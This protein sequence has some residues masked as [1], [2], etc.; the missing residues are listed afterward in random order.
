MRFWTT[1]LGL[2]GAGVILA[3]TGCS[4]TY[5]EMP[6]VERLDGLERQRSTKEDVLK[7]LGAPR[8]YGMA[9]LG[10]LPGAR[11]MWFYEYVHG[12]GSQVDLTILLV[13]FDGEKYDGYLWFSS[14]QN[15]ERL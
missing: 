1:V 5:G 11:P 14:S 2:L 13:F 8:G 12:A 15:V 4:V 6:K 7:T 10:T 3:A 9:N